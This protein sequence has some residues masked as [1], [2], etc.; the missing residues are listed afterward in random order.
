MATSRN[1]CE[2]VAMG[3]SPAHFA[4]EALSDPEQALQPGGVHPTS[5]SPTIER[6]T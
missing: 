4:E 5:A 6:L 2:K 1:F 3:T